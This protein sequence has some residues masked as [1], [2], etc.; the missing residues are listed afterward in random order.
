[1]TFM[2]FFKTP[3]WMAALIATASSGFS[4]LERSLPKTEC[5]SSVTIGILVM[6]PTNRISLI[7]SFSR[8]AFS[9]QASQGPFVFMSKGSTSF[10]S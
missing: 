10:S 8:P 1:M 5:T 4:E 3:S 7:S 9:V 2:S 6:P